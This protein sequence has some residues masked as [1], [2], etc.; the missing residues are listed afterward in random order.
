MLIPHQH[1]KLDVDLS[2]WFYENIALR[3][4]FS[5]TVSG[6]EYNSVT[7]VDKVG[8]GNNH[9]LQL[10]NACSPISHG[11]FMSPQVMALDG[12]SL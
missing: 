10:S 7:I 9:R 1:A 6:A 2:Y 5:A 8:V 12:R 11:G 4:Y 3:V